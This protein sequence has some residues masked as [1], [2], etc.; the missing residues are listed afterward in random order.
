[1][2]LR[3]GQREVALEET[4]V[5]K[6][7]QGPYRIDADEKIVGVRVVEHGAPTVLVFLVE[8]LDDQEGS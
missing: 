7:L 3:Q 8:K 4:L 5:R 2:A 6:Y 1:M